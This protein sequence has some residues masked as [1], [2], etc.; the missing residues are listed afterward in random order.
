MKI[1]TLAVTLL[2]LLIANI[3]YAFSNPSLCKTNNGDSTEVVRYNFKER[4]AYHIY[5]NGDTSIILYNPDGSCPIMT[6]Q[7]KEG[8]GKDYLS[9]LSMD[10]KYGNTIYEVD[11]RMMNNGCI[12]FSSYKEKDLSLDD[13]SDY[14]KISDILWEVGIYNNCKMYYREEE[15]NTQVRIFAYNREDGIDYNAACNALTKAHGLHSLILEPGWV[16]ITADLFVNEDTQYELIGQLV[17]DTATFENT[18]TIN[19]KELELLF[20]GSVEESREFMGTTPHPSYCE[21][22]GWS[23][24]LD[25]ETSDYVIEFLGDMCTY[26]NLFGRYDL[27]E[28]QAYFL[29]EASY[30]KEHYIKYQM[31]TRKQADLFYKELLEHQSANLKENLIDF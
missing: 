20:N 2:I 4:L 1:K 15:N 28:F 27:P 10:Y 6:S 31:L 16:I 18:I 11:G 13:D 19:K 7:Y 5:T 30:R 21:V 25:E 17:K 23:H 8:F 3:T 24:N 26:F 22:I 29:K 9:F 14:Y 12:S